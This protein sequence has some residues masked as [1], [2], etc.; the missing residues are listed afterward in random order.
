MTRPTFG[1]MN[2]IVL[3]T[4]IGSDPITIEGYKEKTGIDLTEVFDF[5]INE[6]SGTYIVGVSQKSIHSFILVQ[7]EE[8]NLRLGNINWFEEVGGSFNVGHM[9]L[10]ADGDPKDGFGLYFSINQDNPTLEGVEI[11][12]AAI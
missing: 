5:S 2:V 4:D 1:K 7:S 12:A 6:A 3:P 11:L 8:Y 10:S 9:N